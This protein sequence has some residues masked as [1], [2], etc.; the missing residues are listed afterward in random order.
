MG[1]GHLLAFLQDLLPSVLGSNVNGLLQGPP[2]S[3][4]VR[5]SP[6]A[7]DEDSHPDIPSFL[8]ERLSPGRF[9]S[10]PV[11]GPRGKWHASIPKHCP[12]DN[13]FQ[14]PSQAPKYRTKHSA[15]EA[16]PL[17]DGIRSFRPGY[18]PITPTHE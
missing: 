13:Q 3:T 11:S 16:V 10:L 7:V 15:E 9:A 8:V 14:F 4:P 1:A 17:A 2:H 5:H 18:Y 6:N 12:N